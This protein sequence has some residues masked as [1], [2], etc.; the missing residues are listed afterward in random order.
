[1]NAVSTMTTVTGSAHHGSL[2]SVAALM[3]GRAVAMGWPLMICPRSL[4]RVLSSLSIM[5]P[6]VGRLLPREL[7]LAVLVEVA[8]VA[9]VEHDGGKLVDLEP[10]DALGAEVL[11]R[12]E[13]RLRDVPREQGAGAADGAEVDAL[14]LLQRVLHRLAAIALADGGLEPQLQQRRRELVHAAGRGR[15]DGPDHLP[16]LGRRRS[17]VVDDCALDVDGQRLALL[18]QRQQPAVSG[19]T[20]RVEHAADPHPIPGLE[21]LHVGVAER[22]GDVLEAVVAG[23]DAHQPMASTMAL[24][25]ALGRMAFDACAGFGR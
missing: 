9:V 23:A 24:N 20:R 17:R 3:A 14:E 18:D 1:M 6:P 16:R 4:P 22:R 10:A 2:R 8:A 7:L 21:R 25:V 12:D 13:L 11:V 5:D 19:I 15:A